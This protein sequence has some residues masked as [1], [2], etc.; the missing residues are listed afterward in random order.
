MARKHI[1]PAPVDPTTAVSQVSIKEPAAE[2][3]TFALNEFIRRAISIGDACQVNFE[4]LGARNRAD[5]P[6]VVDAVGSLL[7][8]EAGALRYLPRRTGEP[9]YLDLVM[10]VPD[11]HVAVVM[12]ELDPLY[13]PVVEFSAAAVR[14][15]RS[16]RTHGPD[17]YLHAT[18][19][20]IADF[21]DKLSRLSEAA[22]RQCSV[23]ESYNGPQPIEPIP[24]TINQLAE[25]VHRSES[26]VRR[27]AS[28]G[29][30]P[31][32]QKAAGRAPHV[33]DYLVVRPLLSAR[34]GVE[35]AD[36]PFD[37]PERKPRKRVKKSR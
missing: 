35:E 30:W 19:D 1:E 23:L 17:G 10:T 6:P 5:D 14:L 28:E 2:Q 26:I 20:D 25:A 27:W 15:W 31:R 33:Y 16:L 22:E 12:W 8:L 24:A 3:L 4:Q 11:G 36:L 32:L 9:G 34:A 18:H 21:R 7:R 13:R 29:S 37:P